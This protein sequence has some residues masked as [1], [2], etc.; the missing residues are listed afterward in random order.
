MNNGRVANYRAQASPETLEALDD[1]DQRQDTPRASRRSKRR[2]S[3]WFPK[4]SASGKSKV[5]ATRS[6]CATIDS[7]TDEFTLY[8][9]SR[10]K[11]SA[12]RPSGRIRPAPR[13]RSGHPAST[14]TPAKAAPHVCPEGP[15]FHRPMPRLLSVPHGEG[16]RPGRRPDAVAVSQDDVPARAAAERPG[17][18]PLPRSHRRFR[19]DRI[20]PDWLLGRGGCQGQPAV[21]RQEAAGIERLFFNGSAVLDQKAIISAHAE[22]SGGSRQTAKGSPGQFWI[23]PAG[24]DGRR[25]SLR[26]H[27]DRMRP[28]SWRSMPWRGLCRS[29]R[30]FRWPSSCGGISTAITQ[31]AISLPFSLLSAIESPGPSPLRLHRLL[32]E[33]LAEC[34]RPDASKKKS[35]KR[36][37]TTVRDACTG[38][39]RAIPS[40]K[41]R[42]AVRLK[43]DRK[44]S[45]APMPAG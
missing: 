42:T 30:G 7:T 26:R 13:R 41:W 3:P 36:P 16:R 14:L 21:G 9:L 44:F 19:R 40:P 1:K 23:G 24:V 39:S 45:D 2:S 15:G 22:A 31:Q 35:A 34:C 38:C 18:V 20:R 6:S 25:R 27:A 17:L 10:R 5:R 12:P 8:E 4:P 29:R 37:P 28:R 33:I 32:R 43:D 11:R